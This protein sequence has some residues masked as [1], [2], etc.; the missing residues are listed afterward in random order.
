L[1]KVTPQSFGQG[2][3]KF[4]PNKIKIGKISLNKWT[5]SFSY[6]WLKNTHIAL[7]SLGSNESWHPFL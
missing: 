1:S 3:S 6:L 7:E 5:P 4:K 2:G